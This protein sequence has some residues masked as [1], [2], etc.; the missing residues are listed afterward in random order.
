MS[1]KIDLEE[2]AR[3]VAER[4]FGYLLTVGDDLRPKAV[5]VTPGVTGEVLAVDG[6]GP[7]TRA[8]LTARSDVT[9]VFPPTEVGGYSLI[10]DGRATPTDA[11]ARI[12]AGHA[13][14]HRPA[15]HAPGGA[16]AGDATSCGNDCVPLTGT[17]DG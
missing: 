16:A 6:L 17:A 12:V 5:A 13:V 11:G 1:V 3:H 4:R 8:N 15:D 2:L 14:L 10:V 9:L 7:G